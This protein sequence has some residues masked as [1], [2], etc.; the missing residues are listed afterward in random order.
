MDYGYVELRLKMTGD[1]ASLAE[2]LMKHKEGIH[3]I[4]PMLKVCIPKIQVNGEYLEIGLSFP[5][6]NEILKNI[7]YEKLSPIVD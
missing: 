2:E 4:N 6:F 3:E 7:N 5:C 1:S